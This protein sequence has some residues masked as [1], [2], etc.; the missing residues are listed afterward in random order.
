MN[1]FIMEKEPNSSDNFKEE[2]DV[3]HSYNLHI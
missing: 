1:I 3:Y 2:I